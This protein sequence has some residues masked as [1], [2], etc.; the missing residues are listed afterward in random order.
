[1]KYSFLLILALAAAFTGCAR[2]SNEVWDD[3]KS[4]TR[5][6]GHGISRLGGKHG[7]SRQVRSQGDFYP[8]DACY[9]EDF[10]PL[11]D[12]DGEEM[13][14]LENPQSREIPG[15]AGGAIPG[16]NQFTD[17]STHPQLSSIFRNIQFGYDS[18]LV[19]G[20][21][22]LNYIHRIAD[23][24]QTNPNTYIFIEGHCD[25]RGPQAYNYALGARRAN[26]VR[27]LLIKLNTHP[28]HLFTVSYGK[29]RPLV[30][31]NEESG[32]SANRRVQ[33]KI[34]SRQ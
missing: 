24:L 10:I 22:N 5:Y 31:N 19:K 29:E 17:P 14:N 13:I 4:A 11:Y 16:I 9:E 8:D 2:S 30:V 20:E 33:F 32:W 1:M 3:T 15:E 7:D 23:Y 6:M 25:E 28:D 18:D 12:D 27:N 26:T 21:D 34:Y